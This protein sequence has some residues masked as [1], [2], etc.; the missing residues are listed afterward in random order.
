MENIKE[1]FS[2]YLKTFEILINIDFHFFLIFIIFMHANYVFNLL[3]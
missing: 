3:K 1:T 2:D